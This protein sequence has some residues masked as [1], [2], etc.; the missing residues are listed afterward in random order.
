MWKQLE[1]KLGA[2][3]ESICGTIGE[4]KLEA[5]NVAKLEVNKEARLGAKWEGKCHANVEAKWEAKHEAK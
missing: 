2:K 3:W 1:E 4:A 5:K